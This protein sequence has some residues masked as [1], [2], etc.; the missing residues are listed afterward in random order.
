MTIPR[1]D[2]GDFVVEAFTHAI[3]DRL[4]T[5]CALYAT[6]TT[7]AIASGIG[8]L[9]DV[10]FQASYVTS[11]PAGWFSDADDAIVAPEAGTYLAW[12]YVGWAGSATGERRSALRV[13]GTITGGHAYQ[14]SP[15][16]TAW[17]QTHTAILTLAA[18]DKVSVGAAQVSGGGT[19]QVTTKG[20][21]LAR[22]W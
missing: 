13:N 8:S 12:G 9:S 1:L 17:A 16:S 5:G 10:T 19:L 22:L 20:L 7:Q 14:S 15:G 4:N 6:G 21:A 3:A 18:L 11:D 2:D